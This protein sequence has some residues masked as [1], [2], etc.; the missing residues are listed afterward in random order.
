LDGSR[1]RP[2]RAVHAA[3]VPVHG[4]GWPGGPRAADQRTCRFRICGRRARLAWN[5]PSA[6]GRARPAAYGE[7]GVGCGWPVASG[8][9]GSSGALAF[10]AQRQVTGEGKGGW[11]GGCAPAFC[12]G[13]PGP[14]GDGDV[15]PPVG[16]WSGSNR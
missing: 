11:F 4:G 9:R 1:A 10:K 14:A 12:L 15:R 13:K 3:A 5:R 6:L 2:V 16:P 7:V 8:A